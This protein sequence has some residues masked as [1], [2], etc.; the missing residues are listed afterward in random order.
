MHVVGLRMGGDGGMVLMVVSNLGSKA[1]SYSVVMEGTGFAEG[2]QVMDVLGCT[3]ATVGGNGSLT[4]EVVHGMPMVSATSFWTQKL[5]V[6]IAKCCRF[7]I[8]RACSTALDGA[9]D[10]RSGM[11]SSS[12]A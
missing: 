2:G 6:R 9:G 1:G 10:S 5:L 3:E 11:V 4:T 12:P 7:F 8:H